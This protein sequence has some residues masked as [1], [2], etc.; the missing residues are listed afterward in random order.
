MSIIRKL[1]FALVVLSVLAF[2]SVSQAEAL[3]VQ[4]VGQPGLAG[5][6]IESVKIAAGMA[7][8]VNKKDLNCLAKKHLL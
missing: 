7:Q 4:E 3:E 1:H 2:P 5:A 8:P 6:V